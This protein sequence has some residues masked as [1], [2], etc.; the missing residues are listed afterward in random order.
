MMRNLILLFSLLF[1]NLVGFAQITINLPLTRSVF[2]RDNNNTS[3]IYIS[4]NYEDAIEKIEARLLP[5]K[6]GQGIATDWAP[7]I[8][9]P[10]NGSFVGSIKGTGGWY[11]LQVR[12]WKN[13]AVFSQSTVEK[14]GIGEVFLIAGQSNAEGKR[15]YGEKAS[16]DDRIN[17]FDYQKVDF[18][19]EIPPFQSF[20]HIERTS[21][22]A[23]RGQGT[24]CW[25]ELGD[26]LAKRLNVP[27]M[28]FNAAYEGTSIENWY[29]SS[30]GVSTKHPYFKF[31]FPNQTPYSYLR[32]SLQYYISQLGL[33]SVLWQQGEAET[34]LKTTQEYYKT[35]L[36]KVIEKS[37]LES[38]KKISWMLARVSLLNTNQIYP[39]VINAQNNVINPADYIFEGPNTDSIQNPRPEGVHFTDSG[40]SDLAKAWD[41]KMNTRFFSQSIPFLPA[42][43]VPLNA[44]CQVS[45]KVTLSLP[46][47]YNSQKWSNNLISSTLTASTGKYNSVLR[48]QTGNYFFTTAVDVK[49][50]FPTA[51]PVSYAKKS[52][53]FCEGTSTDL[54]TDSPDY[55]SFMWNT[56]ET[57]KQITV[58]NSSSYSVKGISAIGCASP[59]S[60]IIQTQILSLPI[61]PVIYQSDVAAC[62][63]NTITLAS[64]S[65]KES[66][67]STNETASVITIRTV[68]DYKVTVRQKDENGCFSI[69]SE[70]ATFT[71]KPRPETPEIM[72]I[73]IY[74]LQAKQ[75]SQAMD[76]SYEWNQDDRILANKTAFIKINS[77]SF[78]TVTALRNFIVAN[79][80]F[81]CRSNLSG[82]YSFVPSTELS[83][84]IIY[85]N[86]TSNGIVTLE[87]KDNL[88]DFTLTIYNSKGQFIYTSPIPNLTE[89]RVVD[90][91]NLSSGKYIVKLTNGI[92]VEKKS[93]V[94]MK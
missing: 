12:A 77:P 76:L 27:I 45:D 53:F 24:W 5:V 91:S 7:I 81:T 4:G 3:S 21:S 18:L 30:I 22:I 19:D 72:Q 13:G 49:K 29:S 90:L 10:Q 62:E 59:E 25:G 20:S 68:G 32:I 69:V 8:N 40:I 75:K 82:A 41:I 34:D 14:V 23:P 35:A 31:T 94:I 55:T 74:A 89:P 70:P 9:K 44:S 64:T 85:P 56:G 88:E 63:G 37:R 60:N 93:I 43:I 39:T 52:L 2:Q 84:I 46:T 16:F 65:L 78:I 86:P 11:Q 73:G 15:N 66:V 51:K 1:F 17:C 79:K 87:A 38:G 48:D 71:I 47:S 42:P 54:F 58:K 67:W 26:L 61:K 92:Y 50:V 80:T 6:V 83:G 28:F 36:G 57:Q 33:R